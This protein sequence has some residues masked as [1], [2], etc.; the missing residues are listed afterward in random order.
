MGGG[1]RSGAGAF[2]AVGL[3]GSTPESGGVVM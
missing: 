2:A 1:E 3:S